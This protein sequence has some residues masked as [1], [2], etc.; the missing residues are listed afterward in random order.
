M[1]AQPVGGCGFDSHPTMAP[2]APYL[3]GLFPL[4]VCSSLVTDLSSATRAMR[5]QPV[6]GPLVFRVFLARFSGIQRVSLVFET[7]I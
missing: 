5:V 6:S 7:L 2:R 1:R 4:S 3:L